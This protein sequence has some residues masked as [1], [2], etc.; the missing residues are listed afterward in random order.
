MICNWFEYRPDL[1]L[2]PRLLAPQFSLQLDRDQRA[3]LRDGV[4]FVHRRKRETAMKP[5]RT[6][7]VLAS[8]AEARFLV[9]EG[10]GKGLQ[11]LSAMRADDF[12]DTDQEF[13]DQAGRQRAAPGM[14]NHAFAARESVQEARRTTF[15]GL[16]AEAMAAAW[17]TGNHDQIVLA[18]S[19]KLLGELRGRVPKEVASALLADLPK[20]FVK[21]PLRDLP[22]HFEGVAA[23]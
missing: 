1:N 3:P 5:A 6:L 18:A 22:G 14:G 15:A 19:P 13:T 21:T 10:P 7:V 8:E 16:I 20:D 2:M 9:N 4:L 23:F 17:K 12:S 11:E